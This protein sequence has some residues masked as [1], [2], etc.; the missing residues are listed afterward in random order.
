MSQFTDGII[1]NISSILVPLFHLPVDMFNSV[2]SALT[3]FFSAG[4]S[5]VDN[6]PKWYIDQEDEEYSSWSWENV[7]PKWWYD[8]AETYW[9]LPYFVFVGYLGSIIFLKWWMAQRPPITHPALFWG[10]VIHNFA[11]SLYSILLLWRCSPRLVRE[12]S[13]RSDWFYHLACERLVQILK[14]LQVFGS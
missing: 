10:M 13:E 11:I 2:T 1:F 12:F 5:N 6:W 9:W 4:N 3:K 14:V 7:D 8:F